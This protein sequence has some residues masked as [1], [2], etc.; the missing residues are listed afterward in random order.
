MRIFHRRWNG[1]HVRCVRRR[2]ATASGQ[3]PLDGQLRT[4]WHKNCLFFGVLLSGSQ[5]LDKASGR[6]MISC[7]VSS[8]ELP[9]V[10]ASGTSAPTVNG[11]Q[12][13]D[14]ALKAAAL[15]HSGAQSGPRS[16]PAP[17]DAPL[18]GFP[19]LSSPR[20]FEGASA[21]GNG[22]RRRLPEACHAARPNRAMSGFQKY[23]DDQLLRNPGGR[24]YYL[25]ERKVVD[26]IA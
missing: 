16:V 15:E 23:K 9:E 5:F 26:S 21:I 2:I 1:R 11:G 20:I 24:S 19:A 22:R 17:L 10:P 13:F 3:A 8:V 14:K 12:S 6:Q 4:A 18:A 7:P 25:D